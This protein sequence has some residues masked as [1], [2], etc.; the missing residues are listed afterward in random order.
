MKL[1]KWSYFLHAFLKLLA[2]IYA[3]TLIV[4]GTMLLNG[5]EV[6]FNDFPDENSPFSF[7][8]SSSVA[9]EKTNVALEAGIGFF[10][11]VIALIF[12]VGALW[13]ASEIFRSFSKG[14]TPFR[15]RNV[16]RIKKIAT[17]TLCYAIIPQ[18]LYSLL[19]TIFIPGYYFSLSIGITFLLA[20]AFFILA[21]VFV[22]RNN[23][24]KSLKDKLLQEK[25][26][27]QN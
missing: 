3:G 4:S 11:A 21:E 10:V 12:L 8:M 16:K 15:E 25:S 2:I 22:Y 13:L 6:S 23:V 18:V 17:L 26:D 27:S 1:T 20:I 19:H 7:T 9:A 24:E 5:G 14:K